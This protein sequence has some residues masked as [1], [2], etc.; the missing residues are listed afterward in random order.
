MRI[1]PIVLLG[2]LVAVGC[3]GSPTKPDTVVT[4]TLAV[5]QAGTGGDVAVTFLGVTSDSRCPT[6]TTCVTAGDA[7]V[8]VD[9]TVAG[10][11]GRYDLRSTTSARIV[12]RGRVILLRG[13]TPERRTTRSIDARDYQATIQVGGS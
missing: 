2:A 6:D 13:L 7:I 4:L 11:T 10:D 5:G 12:H 1:A 9:V 8:S 3:S